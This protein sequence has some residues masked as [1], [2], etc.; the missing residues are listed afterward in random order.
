MKA[1]LF[2]LV[3]SCFVVFS[4]AFAQV[5]TPTIKKANFDSQGRLVVVI[6]DLPASGCYV[7]VNGGLTSKKVDTGITSHILTDA[8][9]AKSRYQLRTKRRYYCRRR[10]LYVNVESLCLNDTIGQATSSV[11][12]VS[13]PSGSVRR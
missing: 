4:G 7:S 9:A 3:V 2:S 12:A 1:S 10:T 6:S 11:R 13:V 8:E 5:P